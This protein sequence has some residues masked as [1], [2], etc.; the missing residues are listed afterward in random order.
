MP[1]QKA[2][3]HKP[4][5]DWVVHY[6]TSCLDCGAASEPIPVDGR[7]SLAGVDPGACP[8]CGSTRTAAALNVWPLAPITGRPPERP[9]KGRQNEF[10]QIPMEPDE[11][12]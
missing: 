10:A 11:T 9:P 7:A 5:T 6:V 4:S 3:K 8:D 12:P 2:A 1:R